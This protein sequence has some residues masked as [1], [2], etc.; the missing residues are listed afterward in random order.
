MQI[1][2][3]SCQMFVFPEII[4]AGLVCL[5]MARKPPVGQGFLI[6]DISRS[7]TTMHHNQ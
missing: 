4:E 2:L 7:H 5:F 1:A 3:S 6:H